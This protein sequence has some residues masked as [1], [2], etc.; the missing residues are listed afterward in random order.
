MDLMKYIKI[1]WPYFTIKFHRLLGLYDATKPAVIVEVSLIS[2][3][4]L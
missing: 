2:S 3:F 4:S 1:L